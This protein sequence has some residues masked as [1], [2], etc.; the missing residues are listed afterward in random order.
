MNGAVGKIEWVIGW[1]DWRVGTISDI[2][3]REDFSKE[4]ELE[5]RKRSKG[6]IPKTGIGN[7]TTLR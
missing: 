2:M 7:T 1:R 5:L 3:I 4:V 6:C